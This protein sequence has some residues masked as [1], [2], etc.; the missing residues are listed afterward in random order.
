MMVNLCGCL[1]NSAIGITF[2]N[3]PV[4]LV[5]AVVVLLYNFLFSGFLVVSVES[6]A[7]QGGGAAVDMSTAILQRLSFFNAAYRIIVHEEISS[8]TFFIDASDWGVSSL[9]PSTGQQMLS[10]IGLEDVDISLCFILLASFTAAFLIL[11]MISLRY[12][13]REYR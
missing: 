7:S 6:S 12:F 8:L 13:V 5:L 10:Q 3:V 2:R 1:I 4:A 9:I 11:N